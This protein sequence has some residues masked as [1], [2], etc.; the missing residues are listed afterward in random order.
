MKKQPDELDFL[1]ECLPDI[2]LLVKSE[3]VAGSYGFYSPPLVTHRKVVPLRYPD[4]RRGVSFS[5]HD[6][7]LDGIFWFEN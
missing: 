7:A 4:W 3:L 6:Q 5:F 2:V 1:H